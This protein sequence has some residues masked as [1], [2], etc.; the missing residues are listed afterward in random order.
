VTTTAGPFFDAA[1]EGFLA[2]ERCSAC[3]KEQFALAGR[4]A[5][6]ERCRHCAAPD[7]EWVRASGTGVLISYTIVPVRSSDGPP[8][9]RV[10]GIIEL[11][12]GPWIHAA[13]VAEPDVLRPGLA[14]IVDF[15][16]EDANLPAPLFWRVAPDE[17]SAG[18]TPTLP[19]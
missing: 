3:G 7:P 11:V 12:E 18:G 15:P 19:E 4:S 10:A 17:V 16:G 13:I 2:I 14:M 1:R 9:E 5:A 6:I 8:S